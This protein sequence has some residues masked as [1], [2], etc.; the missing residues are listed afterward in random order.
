[1]RPDRCD[2]ALL[3]QVE[4]HE[5]TETLATSVS[6]DV[7]DDFYEIPEPLVVAFEEARAALTAA[8]L[9]ISGYIEVNGLEP[10]YVDEGDPTERGGDGA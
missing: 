1:M 2:P 9:A 3:V 6:R 8:E 10:Q 7:F 4:V 5:D